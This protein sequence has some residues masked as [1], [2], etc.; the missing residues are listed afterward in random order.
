VASDT[1]ERLI[2]TTSR[3]LRKQGYAATGLN[4]VMSEA[5]AP[6]G[7]MYFHFPGGKEELAAAA[8][9]RFSGQVHDRMAEG[10]ARADTV[11]AAVTSF[12][13][14][15]I[16]RLQRKDYMEGCAI[17][18]VALDAA[19]DHPALADVTERGLSTWIDLFTE[20]LEAERRPPEDARRLAS[21][22]VAALEGIIVLGKGMRSTEPIAA[23]RDALRPLLAAPVTDSAAT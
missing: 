4:Q 23:A 21:L 5:D 16:A 19:A 2:R 14:A 1:R 8:L 6:K 3:L 22:V 17:A 12:F 10:L 20:A 11:E 18:A 15:E 13:D 7:S 9:D